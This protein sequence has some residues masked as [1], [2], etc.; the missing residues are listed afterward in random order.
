M[1][2]SR[3]LFEQAKGLEAKA[4]A[5]EEREVLLDGS[6]DRPTLVAV[7]AD[8]HFTNPEIVAPAVHLVE[9]WASTVEARIRSLPAGKTMVG[10]AAGTVSSGATATS[11]LVA[12]PSVSLA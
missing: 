6:L 4:V 12:V 9:S 1:P 10:R 3:E 7:L 5:L 2:R 11:S 8:E